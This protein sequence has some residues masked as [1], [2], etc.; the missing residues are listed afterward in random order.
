M[1]PNMVTSQPHRLPLILMPLKLN[2][3]Q[4]EATFMTI[5]PRWLRLNGSME[6]WK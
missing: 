5:L 4:V 3:Q 2:A 6:V 1:I